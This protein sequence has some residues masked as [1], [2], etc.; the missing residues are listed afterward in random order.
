MSG[1]DDARFAAAVQAALD[2]R[3]TPPEFAPTWAAAQARARLAQPAAAARRPFRWLEPLA[4]AAVVIVVVTVAVLRGTGPRPAGDTTPGLDATHADAT[5]AD[6]VLERDLALARALAPERQ[7]RTPSDA[8]LDTRRY[9][10]PAIIEL[11]DI[12]NPFEE[13]FL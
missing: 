7:W 8:L 13:S 11:P 4:A 5:R 10:T 3:T 6:A 12:D 9:R 2:E 1:Q